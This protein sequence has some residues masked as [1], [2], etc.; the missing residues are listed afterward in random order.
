VKS[1]L[2]IYTGMTETFANP[3]KGSDPT[4]PLALEEKLTT[5]H[6]YLD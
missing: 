2:N 1:L 6:R 5:D 4:K 3:D